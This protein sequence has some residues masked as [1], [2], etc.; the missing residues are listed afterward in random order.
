MILAKYKSKRN[1]KKSGE[2]KPK[3]KFS[4]DKKLI[5][6]IHRHD[7]S[8]LH[9]DL[10]LEH[11]RVLKSW[12]IPKSPEAVND[13]KTKRLAIQVEDHPLGYANFHGVIPE[14]NYGA[15]KVEIWDKG[16]Y[17]PEKFSDKEIIVDIHG[18]KL[19]GKYVLIKTNYQG[20]KSWLF[21]KRRNN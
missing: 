10:R 17:L 4:K 11:D 21:L 12:A 9:W 14:G 15:G 16:F 6:M 5:Y 2:P 20:K 19:N 13:G 8:H 18:E 1:L 3:I 7:A